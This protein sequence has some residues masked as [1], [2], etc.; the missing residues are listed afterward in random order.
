MS[1]IYHSAAFEVLT[2]SSG[3]ID[4]RARVM[5]LTMGKC[6]NNLNKD[7]R[8]AGKSLGDYVRKKIMQNKKPTGSKLNCGLNFLTW[9]RI[10]AWYGKQC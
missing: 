3:N 5:T 8:E 9:V 7:W 6:F 1:L 2:D 4:L 10:M